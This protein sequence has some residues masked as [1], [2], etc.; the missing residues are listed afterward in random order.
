MAEHIRFDYF[1]EWYSSVLTLS[2]RSG[3]SCYSRSLENTSGQQH[4]LAQFTESTI[5]RG[6]WK[7]AAY[8]FR[9]AEKVQARITTNIIKAEVRSKTLVINC[10]IDV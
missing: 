4:L 6:S 1:R 7:M 5:I 9:H 8:L 2:L 10:T 3:K